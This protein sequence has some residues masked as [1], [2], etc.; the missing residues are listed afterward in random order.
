MSWSTPR[1]SASAGKRLIRPHQKRPGASIVFCSV[2]LF[3]VRC[4]KRSNGPD[5]SPVP[6]RP[7][8]DGRARGRMVLRPSGALEQ[9]RREFDRERARAGA[10]AEFIRGREKSRG[11]PTPVYHGA[12]PG[13]EGLSRWDR[14][15]TQGGR[16]LRNR[17]AQQLANKSAQASSP[18]PTG[19][20][21]PLHRRARRPMRATARRRPRRRSQRRLIPPPRALRQRPRRS[22]SRRQSAK[23]RSPR[24]RSN[25]R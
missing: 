22:R 3:R 17:D 21:P 24:P 23:N 20:S 2:Q 9:R 14:K 18:A 19:G 11:A 16:D 8:R 5:L 6:D 15:R 12:A 1:V 10:R 13:V 7:A 25:H 4:R